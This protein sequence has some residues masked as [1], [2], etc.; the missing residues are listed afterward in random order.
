[1]NITARYQPPGKQPRI[2]HIVGASPAGLGTLIMRMK[3][4]ETIP[5]DSDHIQAYTSTPADQVKVGDTI[6]FDHHR[7]N[8]TVET[9]TRGEHLIGLH[10]NDDTYSLFLKPT[11][12]V[13]VL[14]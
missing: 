1:M 7:Y 13:R 10:A 5:V 3:D 2:G 4:G 8:V 6:T 11:E 9:I 12:T 14:A